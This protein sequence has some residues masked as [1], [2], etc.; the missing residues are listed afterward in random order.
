MLDDFANAPV[1]RVGSLYREWKQS[2][3]ELADLDRSAQEKLRLADLWSFQLK[4]I[5]AVAPQPAEDAALESERRIL[6]NFVHVE[7]TANAA[8][9]ALYDAPE[10]VTAQLRVVVTPRG[11][12]G[13][14]RSR[15]RR[16]AGD[17]AARRHR[18][19]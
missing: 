5:E 12:A 17:L 15:H 2:A 16:R 19:R 3:D 18:R 10:S 14:H 1:D 13:P 7:E 6:R 8:Y 9:A 4:E 11:G